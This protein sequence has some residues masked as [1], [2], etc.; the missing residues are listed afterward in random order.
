[1]AMALSPSVLLFFWLCFLPLLAPCRPAP[2]PLAAFSRWPVPTLSSRVLR[3]Q[4][5]T[6]AVPHSEHSAPPRGSTPQGCLGTALSSPAQVPL[7]PPLPLLSASHAASPPHATSRW[8]FRPATL[9]LLVRGYF[10]PHRRSW[11]PS[12]A[13]QPFGPRHP[14][15]ALAQGAV[16]DTDGERGGGRKAR[17]GESRQFE[18]T[19]GHA[20]GRGSGPQDD[21]TAGPAPPRVREAQ[22]EEATADSRSAG[23]SREG[24][25]RDG[26]WLESKGVGEGAARLRSSAPRGGGLRRRRQGEGGSHARGGRNPPVANGVRRNPETVRATPAEHVRNLRKGAALRSEPPFVER[27]NCIEALTAR[28]AQSSNIFT[29]DVA[30]ARC[31]EP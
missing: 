18:G 27:R 15:A 13:L 26:G 22:V 24:R 20:A 17:E 8:I 25:G 12:L 29:G 10:L 30:R 14:S 3:P 19:R 4:P 28:F 11:A 31:Q 6:A 16:R 7:S 23:K 5:W 1:M 2:L 21:A 9:Q